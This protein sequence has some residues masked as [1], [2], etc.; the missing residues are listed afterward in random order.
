MFLV[1]SYKVG[2]TLAKSGTMLTQLVVRQRLDSGVDSLNLIHIRH[3]LLAVFI[4]L[5]AE[6]KFDYTC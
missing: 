1:V 3:N 4:G 6:E 5:A 2:Y